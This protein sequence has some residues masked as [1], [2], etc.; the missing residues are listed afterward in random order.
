MAQRYTENRSAGVLAAMITPRLI[1]LTYEALLASHWRRHAL[2]KFLIA[3]HVSES[4]LKSWTSDES[5][6]DL[7][8]R[9]FPQLQASDRGK[10]L[11]LK[12]ARSLAEKTTFPDLRNWE[13]SEKKSERR[14]RRCKN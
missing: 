2:H 1:E 13:D 11:I 14:T 8:D 7:L 10:A 9:L 6:R 12:M 4:F 5:K 3:S